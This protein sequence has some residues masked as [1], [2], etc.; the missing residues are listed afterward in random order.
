MHGLGNDFV[1]FDGV[2]SRLVLDADVVRRIA[3]RRLGIGCDQVL[4]I[5]PSTTPGADFLYRIFNADG[6]EVQQCGNGSRCVARFLR[7]E[8][9]ITKD[10]V[11][12]ATAAGLIRMHLE[13]DDQVRVAMGVPVFEPLAIPFQA[14]ERADTYELDVDGQA[15]EICALSM[16]N[17]HAVLRVP[18]VANAPVPTLGPRISTHS[19]FPEGVNAGFMQVIDR[20]HIKLRVHERGAGE[21]PACGTGA[22]AAMVAGRSQGWLDTEVEVS[23]QGGLLSIGWEGPGESV[24]MR[25]P[26]AKVFEGHIPL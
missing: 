8:G 21:T 13:A 7:D 18:D 11:T 19:R 5:E 16:G 6:G 4:L 10:E 1:V 22:C 3:D 15:I 23:L 24:W 12:V 2:R 25:G 17:P 14:T 20:G 26:T 9:L